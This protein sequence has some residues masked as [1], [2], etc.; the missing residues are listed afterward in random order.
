[1]KRIK[2]LPVLLTD[3]EHKVIKIEAVKMGIS[4]SN[5]VRMSVNKFLNPNDTEK[6]LWKL[7]D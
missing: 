5:L 6:Q 2:R 4:A 3:E 1:M 7:K